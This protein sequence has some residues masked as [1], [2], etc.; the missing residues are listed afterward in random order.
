MRSRGVQSKTVVSRPPSC[1]H[2]S[3]LVFPQELRDMIHILSYSA[4]MNLRTSRSSMRSIL[5]RREVVGRGSARGKIQVSCNT[6]RMKG[7]AGGCVIVD[8]IYSCQSQPRELY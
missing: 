1:Q 5:T 4:S 2:I 7:E 8:S 6:R 3:F